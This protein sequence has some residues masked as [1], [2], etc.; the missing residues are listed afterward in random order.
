MSDASEE[1]VALSSLE[2]RTWVV[3]EVGYK[4]YARK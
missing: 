2:S 3:K 1:F 4:V